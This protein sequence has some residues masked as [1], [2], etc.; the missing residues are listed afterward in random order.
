MP[1]KS[2][3]LRDPEKTF[4]GRVLHNILRLPVFLLKVAYLLPLLLFGLWLLQ[5]L[6]FPQLEAKKIAEIVKFKKK[7]DIFKTFLIQKDVVPR[8]HFHMI[9]EYV[10]RKEALLPLC[11]TC[12]GTYPHSKEKKVRAILNFH[13]GFIACSVCHARKEP[14]TKNIIFKWVD[15]KTGEILNKVKG[16]YGKYPAEIFPVKIDDKGRKTIFRPVD[17]KAA[18]H[19]LLIK[20]KL[21]SDQIAQAKIKLH[22]HISEKPVF[23]SDCHKKNGYLDFIKLGF[24]RQ[25]VNHLNSTE[26]VGM[27]KKYKTFYLPNEIDFGVEK[28]FK[29]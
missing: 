15:W 13:T 27:I 29:Q 16:E 4:A 3:N 8:E 1:K 12:H 25:R 11:S 23:C 28:V 14:G 9:D 2:L 5:M 24:S 17:D 20:D 21:N 19:Y 7:E 6:Y 22:E 10:T 26:V 18:R